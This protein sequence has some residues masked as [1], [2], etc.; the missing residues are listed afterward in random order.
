M[1]K[2]L[3]D[4]IE[5]F[6][7]FSMQTVEDLREL[8]TEDVYFKDPFNELNSV[9]GMIHAMKDVFETA[10]DVSFEVLD[11]V[12]EGDRAYLKWDF[13]FKPKKLK[14]EDPWNV[15]GLSEVRFRDGKVCS[16]VD[17]WDAGSGFYEKLPV[18]GV[19]IRFVKK[20]LKVEG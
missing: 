20:R 10:D 8:V 16:H 12:S 13:K 11:C 17:Y 5:Y 4:Y 19:G 3:E 1:T 18:L 7:N 2:I 6:N 14:A 9:E 15:V